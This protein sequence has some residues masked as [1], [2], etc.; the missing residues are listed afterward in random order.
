MY[1]TQVDGGFEPAPF[2]ERET[3]FQRMHDFRS[4]LLKYV[5]FSS[6]ALPHEIVA[7]YKGRKKAIYENAM[8][9]LHVY[10]VTRK[11]SLS[12]A[13]VKVE[14]GNPSKAPR[15]IQP[16]R[17]VY[18]LALA[19][20]IKPIEHPMYK[21]IKKAFAVDSPVVAKGYNLRQIAE[22]IQHKWRQFRDPVGLGIDAHRFDAHC[23]PEAIEWEHSIYNC[24]YPGTELQK[25]LKWQLYNIGAGYCYDGK[26]RYK[27]KGKRFSGDMNTGLGNVIIM[28]GLVFSYAKS[29]GIKIDLINN[30]DD[31]VV[32]MENCDYSKFVNGFKEWSLDMGY[33]MTVEPPV[34]HLA[35]VEFCQMHPI[36]LAD[37]IIMVRNIH[38]STSK[39]AL[40]TLNLT[41]AKLRAKWFAAVGE[42][43]SYVTGGVPIVNEFYQTYVR[44]GGG[45][46][47]NITRSPQFQSSGFFHLSQGV[48]TL[49]IPP[50]P[51][52][53]HDVFLA[54]GITPDEQ[55]VLED[56]YR[57]LQYGDER[58]L[59]LPDIMSLQLLNPS[60]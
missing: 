60:H 41:N 50:I 12:L 33:R 4:N 47:S 24:M 6:P 39:D 15:C 9:D 29:R 5:K 57:T 21:A 26:L 20:Y 54:W 11:D 13:F 25:L 59:G 10:G 7:M 40:S 34:K 19:R 42:C 48:E 1:Y 56:Y 27:V 17:P 43:G 8:N 22:I 38:T 52:T 37:G 2:V 53:R 51:E 32:F 35:K 28:T 46:H 23:S 36:R 45:T 49:Q 16:R 3:F 18:N 14:K 55:L 30:G 58:P 31:C 44:W